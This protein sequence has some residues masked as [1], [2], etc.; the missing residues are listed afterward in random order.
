MASTQNNLSGNMKIFT[1]HGRLVYV[2]QQMA[3]LP[4]YKLIRQTI[5]TVTKQQKIQK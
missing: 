2:I 3:D 1:A 5:A 4:Y